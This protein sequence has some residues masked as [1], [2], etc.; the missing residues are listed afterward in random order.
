[1]KPIPEDDP[2][3]G[4]WQALAD[5][6]KAQVICGFAQDDAAS[7]TSI[8]VNSAMTDIDTISS[9]SANEMIIKYYTVTDNILYDLN[10]AVEA[11][12]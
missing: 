7:E 2:E 11:H 4:A 8:D 9:I 10:G 12:Q 3:H 6:N 5:I 1:M